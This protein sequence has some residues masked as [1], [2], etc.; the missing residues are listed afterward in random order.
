M[1]P[2]DCRYYKRV[3]SSPA[4]TCWGLACVVGT[5]L[6]ALWQTPAPTGTE[7]PKPPAY[8]NVW[9]RSAG[10]SGPL[11]VRL[12]RA[13]A[14]LA[15]GTPALSVRALADG[16]ELW[17]A[18]DPLIAPVVLGDQLVFAASR[19]RLRAFDELSGRQVW[20]DTLPDAPA[21]ILWRASWLFV[22][23]GPELRAY[24]ATD[25]DVQ[26]RVALSAA[27][28][29]GPAVDGDAL[30]VSLDDQSL[31]KVDLA[32]HEVDWTTPL[33]V[34]PQSLLAANGRIYFGGAKGGLFAYSQGSGRLNWP[35]TLAPPAVGPPAADGKHVYFTVADN[36]IRAFH[37]LRGQEIW[38]INLPNRPRAGVILAGGLV[39]VP[40]ANGEIST[41]SASSNG[42]PTDKIPLP[43]LADD[44]PEVDRRLEDAVI[45][46]DGA[47][48][49]RVTIALGQTRMVTATRRVKGT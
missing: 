28:Q 25:G 49:I 14:A 18:A 3:T 27:V 30:F 11:T 21:A 36:T 46:A 6:P 17:T 12:G 43:A 31:V 34:R 33:D 20:Q 37:A 45:S 41:F 16:R 23:A 48:V 15:G 44:P 7:G 9:S 1:L 5:L 32:A 29:A 26:W 19:G 4:T 13:V 39:A 42:R 38:H 47:L 24:R 8:E 22:V 35:F 10:D 2:D 40:L